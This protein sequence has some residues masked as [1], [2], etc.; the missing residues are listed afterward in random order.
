MQCGHH[1]RGARNTRLERSQQT[2]SRVVIVKKEDPGR[3]IPG[4]SFSSDCSN[5]YGLLAAS[6]PSSSSRSYCAARG[7]EQVVRVRLIESCPW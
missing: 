1:S 4:S 2:L 3:D 6:A 5:C 7:S